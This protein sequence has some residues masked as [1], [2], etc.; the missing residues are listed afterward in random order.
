MYTYIERA[1]QVCRDILDAGVERVGALA[2]QFCARD[3]RR[4]LMVASGSSYNIALSM[5]EFMQRTLGIEVGATWPMSYILYNHAQ[6]SDTFVLCLSQSGKSTNTIEAVRRAQACGHDVAVL[7]TNGQA[8]IHETCDAV[9]EYGSGS[10]DYYV[11]KGY[12]SSCTFLASFTIEAAAR[13]GSID[14]AARARLLAGLG[15]AVDGLAPVM[16]ESQ[17]FFQKHIDRVLRT[18]RIMTVGIGAGYG[19]ALEGALKLNEMTGIAANAYEME[20]F[21]HGPTYEIRKDHVVMLVDQGGPGHARLM[22]LYQALHLLTDA[23]FVIDNTGDYAGDL[24]V[25]LPSAADPGLN[26]LQDVVPFQV[27]AESLCSALDL[28]SYNFSNYDFEQEMKT[29]A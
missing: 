6:A 5:C 8:P 22:Q 3:Y 4:I 25:R 17:A 18:R 21:V 28:L 9:Y 13:R 19:V 11:A 23:V 7:T 24:V 16:G 29:K 14:E 20:E 15:A 1:P 2:E 27:L 12:P 26:I 10:D